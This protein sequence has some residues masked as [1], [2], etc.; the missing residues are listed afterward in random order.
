MNWVA[1]VVDLPRL[2]WSNLISEFQLKKQSINN[3]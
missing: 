1:K 2:G 3:G